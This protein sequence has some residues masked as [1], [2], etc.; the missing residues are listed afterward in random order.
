MLPSLSGGFRS[1]IIATPASRLGQ[2]DPQVSEGLG[3]ADVL[4]DYARLCG[5]DYSAMPVFEPNR[6]SRL[7]T[8]NSAFLFLESSR[9]SL[10]PL[11]GLKSI[12]WYNLKARQRMAKDGRLAHFF[13]SSKFLQ[14]FHLATCEIQRHGFLIV[15][16]GPAD[17]AD[18]TAG[19]TERD[20]HFKL[21]LGYTL[22]SL[23]DLPQPG[24]IRR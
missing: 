8:S 19:P 11:A 17:V 5:G 2:S 13:F 3:L 23:D 24:D 6:E 22:N 10:S 7:S 9:N 16:G 14:R 1:S 21:L 20:A 18:G 4:G 12:N 15:H